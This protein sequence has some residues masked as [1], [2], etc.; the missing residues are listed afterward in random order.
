MLVFCLSFGRRPRRL[1]CLPRRLR[2]L[3]CR[4]HRKPKVAHCPG[5]HIDGPDENAAKYARHRPEE[6]LLYRIVARHYPEFVAAR[7]ATGRPLPQYV[8]LA[9]SASGAT[10]A[11][12][13]R[14]FYTT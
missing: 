2:L 4:P 5:R 14:A 6:T 1:R 10:L 8:Q 9:I 11:F 13:R 12:D 3:P 7:E